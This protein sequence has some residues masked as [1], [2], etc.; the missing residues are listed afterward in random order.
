[1]EA[2]ETKEPSRAA[3]PIRWLRKW[4]WW[5][6]GIVLLLA[7]LG[8][9]VVLVLGWHEP[10]HM[11]LPMS[12][13][14][15]EL[16]GTNF[17]KR[18]VA[19][20]ALAKIGEPSLEPLQL[21]LRKERSFVYEL[22][23]KVRKVAPVALQKHI[24]PSW[25]V[26]VLQFNAC[27]GLAALGPLAEP[28]V[29]DLI[30]MLTNASPAL[31]SRA[32][33]ALNQ[34]GTNAHPALLAGMKS[35]DPKLAAQCQQI[36]SK[37]GVV[38]AALPITP[39]TPTLGLYYIAFL[40][41]F[42]NAP[43]ISVD[44]IKQTLKMFN[45]LPD[46]AVATLQI[47]LKSGSNLQRVRVAL[48]LANLGQSSELITQK[49]MEDIE[50]LPEAERVGCACGLRYQGI[51][52]QPYSDR[53]KKMADDPSAQVALQIVLLLEKEYGDSKPKWALVDRIL[54]G[55]NETEWLLMRGLLHD[56]VQTGAEREQTIASLRRLLASANGKISAMALD[57]VSQNPRIWGGL[58]PEVERLQAGLASH[59][60]LKAQAEK[61]L[62]AM[63][64]ANSNP[65]GIP[66]K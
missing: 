27:V 44:D 22:R 25:P 16:N 5:V 3:T 36:L 62:M 57:L 8:V 61:V 33:Y 11:D 35:S 13:W 54:A 53:L 7:P 19:A 51:H 38:T 17:V 59:D 39:L 66:L 10:K 21:A 55:D 18:R 32:T 49:M 40:E 4:Q 42:L 52:L 28:A 24:P 63:K 45:S 29:P 34:I 60:K 46:D 58:Q 47:K 48:L 64:I 50:Q 41:Q 6:A 14:L 37:A 31:V 26:D 65:A 12:Y 15:A 2:S 43:E 23:D 30:P 56:N 20:E 9:L 1:M